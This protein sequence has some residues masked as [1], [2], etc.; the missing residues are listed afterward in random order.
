MG[1]GI[2]INKKLV[3]TK[4]GVVVMVSKGN[5]TIVGDS[6]KVGPCLD[7]DIQKHFNQIDVA[8][9][10]TT[11]YIETNS[12]ARIMYMGSKLMFFGNVTYCK[13]LDSGPST[14]SKY[15]IEIEELAGMLKYQYIK[16]N[17]KNAIYISNVGD[18]LAPPN[19]KSGPKTIAF[20]VEQ[21]LYDSVW[22]DTTKST[23]TKNQDGEKLPSMGFSSCTIANALDRII[24]QE[25][26]WGIWYDDVNNRISYG[27]F[28]EAIGPDVYPCPSDI[29]ATEQTRNYDIRNV[30]VYNDD[31]SMMATAGEGSIAGKTICYRYSQCNNKEELNAVASRIY[32]DRKNISSRYEIDF[33]PGYSSIHVGDV[34]NIWC[35]A[36]N[37]A[38]RIDN[39]EGIPPGYG[40]KDIRYTLEKTTVGVGAANVTI[41]DILNDRLSVIDGD[42]CVPDVVEGNTGWQE[43]MGGD[44]EGEVGEPIDIEFTLDAVQIWGGLRIF[45]E[46]GPLG[47]TDDGLKQYIYTKVLC[48]SDAISLPPNT[49]TSLE[50]DFDMD[51]IPNAFSWGEIF[52]QYTFDESSKDSIAAW[53]VEVG[54]LEIVDDQSDV[55][56]TN[57]TTTVIQKFYIPETPNWTPVNPLI[58]IQNVGSAN[59]KL[60]DV[61][62]KFSIWYYDYPK[63]H[64]EVTEGV[65]EDEPSDD[66]PTEMELKIDDGEW[67]AIKDC[68]EVYY[69]KL[70]GE[71]KHKFSIRSVD[72]GSIKLTYSFTKFNEPTAIIE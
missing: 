51:F 46:M 5:F 41:F 29:R 22:T 23:V 1:C 31:K 14:G 72:D 55:E 56:I 20:Y 58:M 35:G 28:R 40:V 71:T 39:G 13:K 45:P 7:L 65:P 67:M 17:G 44:V 24:C 57:R 15:E 32:K 18:E 52:I 50:I 33:E 37:M 19:S 68:V 16:R 47:M 69:S 53:D 48:P 36:I 38:E 62:I 4:W 21:V 6:G 66:Y 10:T 27:E 64:K 2:S 60:N 61:S 12:Q 59:M 49:G 3:W 42:A 43:V 26:G 63:H 34:I 9:I 11:I 70:L 54:D 30:I 25:M 8:V